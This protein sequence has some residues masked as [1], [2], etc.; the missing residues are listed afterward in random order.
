MVVELL[1]KVKNLRKGMM[2]LGKLRHESKYLA[3]R[4]FYTKKNWSIEWMCRQLE[5][6]RAAYYKWLHR[7]IPYEEVENIKTCGTCQRIR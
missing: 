2:K 5:I 6:S 1:K 3:I 4:Y 7:E